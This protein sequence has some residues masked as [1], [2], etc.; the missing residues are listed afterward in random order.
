[1]RLRLLF[2]I[3]AT[4]ASANVALAQMEPMG[5][6][7]GAASPDPSAYGREVK[8]AYLRVREATAPFQKLSAAVEAGYEASV[9]MCYA[10]PM[11][12]AMGYHHINR[13]YVDRTLEVEHPEILL[14]ERR[15]DG[16]YALNGVEYI[17]P[18]RLWPADSTPPRLMGR[19]L[20][21]AD[22][23]KVWYMHMWVW[24]PNAEGLFAN[25]NPAAQCRK[26]P[27]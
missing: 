17:V 8:D 11:H 4:T 6:K 25:W 27:A 18:Y 9:D 12:G 14:Y 5:T 2:A 15:A 1:M 22:D 10:D 3:A 16:S 19:D 21:R 20:Q 23:L 13:K 26:P 24:K 7:S